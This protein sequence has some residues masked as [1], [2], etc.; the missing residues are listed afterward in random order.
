MKLSI[1]VPIYNSE[2]FL[3]E[4]IESI[5]NQTFKDFELILVN[6]GSK[7]NSLSICKKWKDI[8][9]RI[10]IIDKENGGVSS[11]R[12]I[13]IVKAKGDY[14]GFIDSD[15]YIEPNMYEELIKPLEKNDIDIVIC[16]LKIPNKKQGYNFIYPIDTVFNFSD[17]L[18]W[19]KLFYQGELETFPVNK[20]Y[21]KAFILNN[22]VT[23]PNYP[24]YEDYI[25]IQNLYINNPIIYF[26]DKE[27]YYYR[28]VIN[29]AVQKYYSQRLE[30]VINIYINNL[31][32][33]KIYDNN[34]Y[35]NIIIRRLRNS[36]INTIIQEK[37]NYYKKQKKVFDKIRNT[38]EFNLIYNNHLDGTNKILL[39]LLY[40]KNYFILHLLLYFNDFFNILKYI[41]RVIK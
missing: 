20:I 33:N 19:K 6:D 38:K 34:I 25:F 28:P 8:D 18:E 12:N 1:I 9:N 16:K 10:V 24:I 30:I 23:F 13:G 37:K 22:N 26:I 4:C 29:S 17:N 41:K 11:A 21:K 7:D 36:I 40:R 14:I 39:K 5:L 32:L 31:K 35:E 15:D 27:L 2:K 3:D